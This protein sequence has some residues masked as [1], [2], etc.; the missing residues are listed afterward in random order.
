MGEGEK[1]IIWYDTL[2]VLSNSHVQ[3]PNG[4][5]VVTITP[6]LVY[7]QH[8]SYC[9]L[10]AGCNGNTP[11]LTVHTQQL[12]AM[13]RSEALDS[14]FADRSGRWG[15]SL[16]GHMA[17]MWP[18]VGLVWATGTPWGVGWSALGHAFVWPPTCLCLLFLLSALLTRVVCVHMHYLCPHQCPLQ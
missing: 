4:C 8:P 17:V 9:Q 7:W 3:H 1:D 5:W 12:P 18:T 2:S 11:F 6:L 14:T 13:N 16:H 15:A 10:K